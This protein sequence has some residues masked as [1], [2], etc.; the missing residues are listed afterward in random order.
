MC[1]KIAHPIAAAAFCISQILDVVY[2]P[3]ELSMALEKVGY[4]ESTLIRVSSAAGGSWM[5]KW[6]TIVSYSQF[7]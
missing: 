3:F 2:V 4:H 5:L 7:H 1:A 6:N